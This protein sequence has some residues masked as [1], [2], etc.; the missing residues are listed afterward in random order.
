MAQLVHKELWTASAEGIINWLN[1]ALQCHLS[2]RY[3][4]QK[5]G[6]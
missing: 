3:F 1:Q 4:V 6:E 5:N 2:N